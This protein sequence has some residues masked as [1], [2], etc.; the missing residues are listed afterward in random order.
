[1]LAA[2]DLVSNSIR[3][4]STFDLA[5]QY[6]AHPQPRIHTGS[7][8]TPAPRDCA[9]KCPLTLMS[10]AQ[11]DSWRIVRGASS[12]LERPEGYVATTQ[13]LSVDNFAQRMSSRMKNTKQTGKYGRRFYLAQLFSLTPSAQL[14]NCGTIFQVGNLSFFNHAAYRGSLCKLFSRGST[15]VPIRPPSRWA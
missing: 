11:R 2:D 12:H 1:M 8:A 7:K 9:L 15:F 6:I 14:P 10:A 3:Y 13:A 5:R 4:A